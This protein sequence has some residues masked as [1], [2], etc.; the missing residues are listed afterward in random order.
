MECV[1]ENE[2]GQ[3]S[4]AEC[5]IAHEQHQPLSTVCLCGVR[6]GQANHLGQPQYHDRDKQTG[7]QTG[8]Q[9]GRQAD[10]EGEEKARIVKTAVSDV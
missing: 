3:E 4:S 1:R 10:K 2:C 8:G 5:F 7:G 9:A 6:R